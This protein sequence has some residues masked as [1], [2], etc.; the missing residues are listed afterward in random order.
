MVKYSKKCKI[1]KVKVQT[2]QFYLRL[3]SVLPYLIA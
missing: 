2:E 1:T 3:T